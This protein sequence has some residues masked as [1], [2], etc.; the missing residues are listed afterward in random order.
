MKR[1]RRWS[2]S[3][4]MLVLL[5]WAGGTFFDLHVTGAGAL[6]VQGMSS[7]HLR[8]VQAE[9]TW[10]GKVVLFDDL[11]RGTFGVA[12]LQ[13]TLLLFWRNGGGAYGYDLQ[14]GAPLQAA[15]FVVRKETEYVERHAAPAPSVHARPYPGCRSSD[16]D[17][18]I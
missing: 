1:W 4:L 7:A 9:P 16:A 15:G 13:R 11:D 17:G 14:A 5:S 12:H 10:F 6:S 2:I 8:I 18:S 3:V